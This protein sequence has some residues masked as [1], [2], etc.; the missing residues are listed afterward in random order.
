MP[1]TRTPARK[2]LLWNHFDQKK[3]QA[4]GF[5]SENMQLKRTMPNERFLRKSM[6]GTAEKRREPLC[7]IKKMLSELARHWR[8]RSFAGGIENRPEALC[9]VE[10]YMSL[11]RV[12]GTLCF[13]RFIRGLPGIT[14]L[15]TPLD[16]KP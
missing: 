12:Q 6:V 3:Q 11:T 16:L 13:E 10:K 9:F 14:T 2:L 8:A 15:Q 4:V 1:K 7:F 5:R